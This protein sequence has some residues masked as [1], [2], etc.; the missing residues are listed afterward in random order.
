[1]FFLTDLCNN[2]KRLILF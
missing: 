2:N 1:M